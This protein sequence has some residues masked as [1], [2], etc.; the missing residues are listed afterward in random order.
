MANLTLAINSHLLKRARI[1]AVQRDTTVNA[2]I[3]D[4]LEHEIRKYEHPAKETIDAL[5]AVLNN[6][7]IPV[8]EITWGREE[9]H[10]R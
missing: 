10:E 6:S 9:L 1:L 4:F 2:M 5:R 8:G 7:Q 3:R